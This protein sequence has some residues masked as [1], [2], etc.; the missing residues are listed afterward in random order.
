MAAAKRKTEN[1]AYNALK[2]D[3]ASGAP[4]RCY[5]LH[6]EERY[7]LERSL[8][9]LRRVILPNGENGFDCRRYSGAPDPD[10]LR[11][12]VSTF[13]LF[14]ARTL[15]EVS[16]CDFASVPDA[17]LS[18]LRELPE[19]VCL[20]FICAPGGFKA[21]K[22]TSAVKELYKLVSVV[23]FE[24]QDGAKL[25]DW[26]RRR[27]E[28]AGV[29]ISPPDAEYLA[30]AAGGYMASLVSEIDKLTAHCAG[31]AVTRADIDALVD[32]APDAVTYKLADAVAAR[33]FRE[34]A[35]VLGELFAMREPAHKIIYALT[36]RAKALLLARLYL[37]EGRGVNELMR[38]TGLRYEFQAKNLMSAARKTTA[39]VCL[40]TVKLCCETAFRLN[41]GGGSESLTELIARLA[42]LK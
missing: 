37:D 2:A 41:D 18:V 4:G 25:L 29:A 21:D 19:H 34:A 24:L 11:E 38:A 16:G 40:K 9:E 26:I 7:L 17:L 14:G 20:V 36:A 22:R 35:S 5:I 33:N 15:V 12:A 8:E 31:G 13:P 1:E 32:T 10:A 30:F 39:Q 23:E 42:A 27:F 28:S 6:G 3:I